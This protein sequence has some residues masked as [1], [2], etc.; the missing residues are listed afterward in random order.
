MSNQAQDNQIQIGQVVKS[1]SD[2]NRIQGLL[3]RMHWDTNHKS[4]LFTFLQDRSTGQGEH[5]KEKLI[6][7]T[8][9][10]WDNDAYFLESIH[11][12]K[13]DNKA[14]LLQNSQSVEKFVALIDLAVRNTSY[15]KANGKMFGENNDRASTDSIMLYEGKDTMLI[16]PRDKTV[17]HMGKF[18]L[19]PEQIA[20]QQQQA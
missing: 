19:T 12:H 17:T 16:N 7:F 11:L 1:P 9:R 6:K 8:V 2:Y 4:A 5:K 18:H 13:E 3:I 15:E 20:K 10:L 14:A